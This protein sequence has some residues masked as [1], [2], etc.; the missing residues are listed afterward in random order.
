MIVLQTSFEYISLY[1]GKGVN[2]RMR[3]MSYQTSKQ[4]SQQPK[5]FRGGE[6]KVMK[7]R[8][9]MLLS[10]AMA[11]S[12]FANVAFGAS[13]LTTQDKF[14]ALVQDGVFNGVLNADGTVDPQLNTQ[15]DRAQ[16]AKIVAILA[17]LEQVTGVESFKDTNYSKHW[18]KG[19]IEAVK[20]AGYM[21]GQGNDIFG[22][23]GKVTGQEIAKT[24]A[25]VLGL[26]P[27]ADAPAVENASEW[28]W[29][30][31]AA[32]KAEGYDWSVDGK[33]NVPVNR[34]IL[35]DAAYDVQQK[36]GVSVK[37]AVAVDE[38]TVKVTFSDDTVKEVKLE[39][40]LVE[41]VA[42]EV[43]VKHDN[44][45]EYKVS[46]TLQA[47]AIEAKVTGLQKIDATLTRA[48]Y[49][50]DAKVE[51]KRGST[52]VETK[53]VKFS[54][55][56]TAIQI[57]L[58][59]KMPAGEYTL[60]L[61]GA[62]EKAVST[63]FTVEEEKVAKIELLSEQAAVAMD[64]DSVSIGFKVTNQY[65]DDISKTA[66]I[67]WNVS[68]GYVTVDGTSLIIK[69]SNGT[70][71][72]GKYMIGEKL[73][74]SGIESTK[75]QTTLNQV[76]TVG[77]FSK[78]DKVEFKGLYNADKKEL[79]TDSDFSTFFVLFDAFDQYGNKLSK[80]QLSTSLFVTSTN[81]SIVD[82]QTVNDATYGQLPSIF[83]KQGANYDSLAIALKAPATS[84][85]K[86]D[87][88][89]TINFIGKMSG[90]QF[91]FDVEVKKAST[92]EKFTLQNPTEAVAVGETVKIPY[93]AYDQN[94]TEITSYDALNS[95]VNVTGAVKKKDPVTK[96]LVIEYTAPATE[97]MAFISS[98]VQ[99]TAST[100]SINF[101]V[102]KEA[103]PA[104]VVGVGSAINL[105][106]NAT[107]T[108]NKDNIK[109]ND[110]YGR[111][112]SLKDAI[113]KGYK[114]Q[115]TNN[116][117]TIVGNDVSEIIAE[118]GSITLTGKAKGYANLELALVETATGKVVTNSAYS[119][120]ANV[121]DKA[122]ISE[123]KLT[124]AETIANKTAVAATYADK[125]EVAVKV[126]GVK[127]DGSEVALA[128]SEY[129][130]ITTNSGLTYNP[131]TGKLT[132]NLAE[133][134]FGDNDTVKAAVI[135]N[136]NSADE[137]T[138]LKQEV[139]ISKVA[140]EAKEI[141]IGDKDGIVTSVTGN[142][143]TVANTTSVNVNDLVAVLKVKDQY[144]VELPANAA[145]LTTSITNLSNGV[146]ASGKEVS[147]LKSGSEFTV[148]Y[149]TA[150]GASVAVKVVVE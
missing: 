100:S 68:K 123:Y 81:P 46:V 65:G 94:G 102:Q 33:W 103:K 108:L 126:T 69:N 55:D 67:N 57:A 148:R 127:A 31:I 140:S 129:D 138:E 38:K 139:T 24:F 119:F 59:T 132:A 143:L 18:A 70:S 145:Q 20:K 12:M 115:L 141:T 90:K 29:G 64:F 106:V 128:K 32:I 28:A 53:E 136:V 133:T 101:Q 27:V 9:A 112:M 142:V 30:Y 82:V 130:V 5:Q 135:V 73:T 1:S 40:A 147:G 77:E 93:V 120:N 36:V 150:N 144:G 134:A 10:V 116:N 39:T 56:K 54:D 35:V 2:R 83:E 47:L 96:N 50:E 16:F 84:G 111:S 98:F 44:G 63:T 42:T 61:S 131:T 41:G 26:E 99:G 117:N 66:N 125:Y 52:V 78:V 45:K 15:T 80:T 91:G 122:A 109:I 92:V 75:Y 97:T 37:S 88:K 114:L 149:Y 105:G 146:T 51:I 7:K 25:T 17:G 58:G 113:A 86:F 110:Q 22:V 72:V 6:K 14:N 23:K 76:V 71:N 137:P 124:L 79:N 62:S 11:F 49:A 107:K 19:Y 121:V 34:S 87:G 104:Q 48:V 85:I 60:T 89:A 21:Q 3:E 74:I 8:L 4:H 43:T 95:L 13:D 118:G